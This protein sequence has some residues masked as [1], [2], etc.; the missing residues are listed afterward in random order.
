VYFC[1]GSAA[2]IGLFVLE[3][4]RR[5]AF[6]CDSRFFLYISRR[7]M[8]MNFELFWKEIEQ[9]AL[10]P[11][12]VIKVQ[13]EQTILNAIAYR[14]KVT[15]GDLLPILKELSVSEMSVL[16]EELHYFEV[17]DADGN[18]FDYP[19]SHQTLMEINRSNGIANM[20]QSLPL[21]RKRRL[22]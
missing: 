2:Y 17:M 8:L 1:L 18:E 20:I 16:Y 9:N 4:E 14:S 10:S 3:E 6:I 15:V 19:N 21:D 13:R 5:F 22:L 7:R 11:D 12:V